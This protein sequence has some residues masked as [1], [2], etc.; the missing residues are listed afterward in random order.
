MREM[1][2]SV[3]FK[4]GLA[5]VDLPRRFLSRRGRRPIADRRSTSGERRLPTGSRGLSGAVHRGGAG[6]WFLVLFF[7]GKKILFHRIPNARH[8]PWAMRAWAPELR[9]CSAWGFGG[10]SP[11][12]VGAVWGPSPSTDAA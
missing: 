12:V 6:L 3:G 4:T 7:S 9:K 1:R 11:W 2:I 5:G 10:I 8:R